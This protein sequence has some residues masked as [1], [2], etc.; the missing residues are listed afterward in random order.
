M[1]TLEEKIEHYDYLNSYRN[2]LKKKQED[3]SPCSS[4]DCT[5]YN[6]IGR[7]EKVKQALNELVVEVENEIAT[8][9]KKG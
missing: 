2:W 8:L 9:N 1:R 4:I 7:L 3:L 5:K 6:A